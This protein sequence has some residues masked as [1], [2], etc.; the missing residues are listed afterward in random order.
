MEKLQKKLDEL[1]AKYGA[2]RRVT[3]LGADRARLGGKDVPLF[4][5]R[6]ERR[7]AEL[8]KL[9][10][11]GTVEGVSV[12]RTAR[13]VQKGADLYAEFCREADICEFILGRRLARAGAVQS[14]PALNVLAVTD[15]GVVCTIEIA[16]T[17][18]E[19]EKPKDKHEIITRRGIACDV[20]VDAQLRQES[21]YVFG[22]KNEAFTDVDFECY[23]L[24]ADEVATVR[25]AFALARDGGENE[26]IE[27]GKR[28][29]EIAGKVKRSA[30]SGER[31]AI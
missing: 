24:T 12:M 9:V 20:V 11:G 30:E 17:L 14:G 26:A 8:K 2:E 5:H 29:E 31:E 1:C 19:G 6:F 25:A 28:L 18:P 16:A 23:G 22:E 15:D 13:T 10:Q 3:I 7:L 27:A 21:I 4:P